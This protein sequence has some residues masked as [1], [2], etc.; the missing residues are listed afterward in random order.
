MI[1]ALRGLQGLF[2]FELVIL[3]VDGSPELARLYGASV[4]VLMHGGRELC[5]HALD[6]AAVTAYLANFR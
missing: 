1:E 4:P 6:T 2:R 3:K 5:R